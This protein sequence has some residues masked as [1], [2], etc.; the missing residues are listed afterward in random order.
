M[1]HMQLTNSLMF[2]S[3]SVFERK[4]LVEMVDTQGVGK[5]ADV[6]R[7]KR[8]KLHAF[9]LTRQHK[10]PVCRKSPMSGSGEP[11]VGGK[12]T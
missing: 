6:A 10:K 8:Q 9:D 4:V 1:M 11:H 12:A 5:K 3:V 2:Y 7:T